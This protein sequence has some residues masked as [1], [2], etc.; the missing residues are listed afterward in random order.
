MKELRLIFI[1][2]T[3]LAVAACAGGPF[4]NMPGPTG[5]QKPAPSGPH[6]PST[7]GKNKPVPKTPTGGQNEPENPPSEQ[8]EQ[9]KAPPRSAA[10][11]SSSAVMSLLNN[12]DK[13]A[14]AGHMDAAAATL[15]RALNLDPRNPFI[16][17]R[18]A[19]ARAEQGNYG[20]A[21]QLAMKSNSLAHGN[22]FVE[23]KNWKLIAAARRAGGNN[24]GAQQAKARAVNYQHAASKY[25]Q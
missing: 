2:S 17:Q 24:Q 13:L 6:T 5:N 3:T 12:A 20:Q 1:L 23:T 25:Q 11:A 15:E 21:E 10:E 22:P 4:N 7:G 9:Q 18:L 19:A 8:Q 14:K 16:Y